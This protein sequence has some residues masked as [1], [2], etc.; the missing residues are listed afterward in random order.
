MGAICLVCDVIIYDIV[1]KRSNYV[2]GQ[3]YYR[4]ASFIFVCCL[5]GDDNIIDTQENIDGYKYSL[6]SLF[7]VYHSITLWS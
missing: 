3:T 5:P 2:R 4:T 7:F 1:K 6:C